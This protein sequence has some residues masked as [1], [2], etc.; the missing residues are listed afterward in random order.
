MLTYKL[1]PIVHGVL[2][3]LTA[4]DVEL[5]CHA[6]LLRGRVCFDDVLAQAGALTDAPTSPET[7]RRRTKLHTRLNEITRA[8]LRCPEQ[9]VL[10]RCCFW[11]E[12]T[13]VGSWFQRACVRRDG[14]HQFKMIPF[15]FKQMQAASRQRD[16][17]EIAPGVVYFNVLNLLQDSELDAAFGL[18]PTT[19]MPLTRLNSET[20][21]W[22]VAVAAEATSTTE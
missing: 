8:V 2:P 19:N 20:Q 14:N 9:G 7:L 1:R 17:A 22:T 13:R 5:I 15:I 6:V 10:L 4:A 21:R 16:N 3:S 11:A 18:E 12:A